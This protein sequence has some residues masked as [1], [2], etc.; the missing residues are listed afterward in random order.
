MFDFS[1]YLGSLLLPVIYISA[2]S[3]HLREYLPAW[4]H[5]PTPPQRDDDDCPDE[6]NN[7]GRMIIIPTVDASEFPFPTTVRMYKT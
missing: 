4:L 6:K 2:D 3:L 5:P 1:Q 7:S